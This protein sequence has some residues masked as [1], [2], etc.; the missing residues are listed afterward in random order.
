MDQLSGDRCPEDLRTI[1]A[2]VGMMFRHL[3]EGAG[4]SRDEVAACL[5]MHEDEIDLLETGEMPVSVARLY[6]AGKL[7]GVKISAFF[8]PYYHP[9]QFT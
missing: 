3:R 9:D 7:F 4:Y 8:A 1:N 6:L 2:V 5:S